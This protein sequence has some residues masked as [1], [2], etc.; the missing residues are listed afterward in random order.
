[1]VGG[2][3]WGDGLS[4]RR[5]EFHTPPRILLRVSPPGRF[6]LGVT[7]GALLLMSNSEDMAKVTVPF[8]GLI[9]GTA[10]LT[11][12]GTAVTNLRGLVGVQGTT[13]TGGTVP[14]PPSPG[15]PALPFTPVQ[16]APPGTPAAQTWIVE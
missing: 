10:V 5:T 4:P 14:L 8:A 3:T 2:T 12:G 9:A 13:D 1:M 6:G 15:S 16:T 11:Q 7:T